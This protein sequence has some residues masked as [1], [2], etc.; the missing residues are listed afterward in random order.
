MNY[1]VG[2]PNMKV[3]SFYDLR[4]DLRE[5]VYDEFHAGNR[6]KASKILKIKERIAI[7]KDEYDAN[8]RKLLSWKY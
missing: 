6:M 1:N 8:R 5:W 2:V 7:R 3:L 4:E